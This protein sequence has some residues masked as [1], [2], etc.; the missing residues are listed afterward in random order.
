MGFDLHHLTG[1]SAKQ[2]VSQAGGPTR[3][4]KAR[5]HC[6][7]KQQGQRRAAAKRAC[8]LP[9]FARGAVGDARYPA[10]DMS[11]PSDPDGAV[12][13][14]A[15]AGAAMWNTGCT[16]CRSAR[17]SVASARDTICR[18]A[19]KSVASARDT[20]CRSARKSVASA[21]D[22]ICRSARKSL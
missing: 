9:S 20:I 8:R 15:A 13:G 11:E 7:C 17:K 21:R 14:A 10:V 3:T 5:M 4:M 19:R 22:T 16:I 6:P 1:W 2:V 18:S 12:S